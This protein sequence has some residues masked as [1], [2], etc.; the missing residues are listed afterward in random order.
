VEIEHHAHLWRPWSPA[1][2]AAQL[3]GVAAPWA[4]AAGWALELFAGRSW[5]EHE[6]IEIAVPAARFDEVRPAL[7]GLELWVP[8]GEGRLRR[9]AGGGE[10]GQTWVLERDAGWRLDVLREPSKGDTWIYRR[11]AGLRIPHA[12]LVERNTDG[13]PFVRP[14]V[15]L[16]FKAAAP[17]PKDEADFDAVAPLLDPA[18]RGWLAAAL[19]RLHPGHAWI[20]RLG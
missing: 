8:V 20:D 12:S 14:E 18:R 7:D 16:L 17:R 13:L 19:R 9:L 3:E 10:P 5:R 11:D 2:T 6:D 4:F 1:E 15:T